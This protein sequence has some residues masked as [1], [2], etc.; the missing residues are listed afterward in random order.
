MLVAA[1]PRG[2]VLALAPLGAVLAAKM[3][4][5]AALAR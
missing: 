4:L 5:A 1:V 3:D 2:E